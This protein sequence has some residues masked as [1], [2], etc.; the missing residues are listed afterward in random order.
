VWPPTPD[1]D[2]AQ[3]IKWGVLVPAP[4]A[5]L[6][7]AEQA[8]DFGG[9]GAPPTAL[10]DDTPRGEGEAEGAPLLSG[11]ASSSSSS[12]EGSSD[13]GSEEGEAEGEASE[14][15]SSS[16]S[17]GWL[18]GWLS[19]GRAGHSSKVTPQREAEEEVVGGAPSGLVTDGRGGLMRQLDPSFQPPGMAPT[20]SK[21]APRSGVSYEMPPLPLKSNVL[22]KR[23]TE[24]ALAAK[25]SGSGAGGPPMRNVPARGALSA[26][27]GGGGGY[28]VSPAAKGG[29]GYGSGGGG[30]GG[31]G[32]GGGGGGYG[33][34]GNNDP[35][36]FA[37]DAQLNAMMNRCAPARS[38][39]GV[40]LHMR[41]V[42]VSNQVITLLLVMTV[43]RGKQSP[44]FVS[45]CNCVARSACI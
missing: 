33:G 3:A 32:S 34:G 35:S 40:C 21:L 43:L 30:G 39:V 1:W 27:G 31:Y 29:G 42:R 37:E 28:G 2:A 20:R 12:E 14:G 13:E 5:L 23:K 15:S 41:G 24:A 19:G 26:G 4:D 25:H 6:A 9:G 36:R 18:S 8:S 10:W 16:S 17:G 11:A 7:A 22:E 45:R 44:I 38:F